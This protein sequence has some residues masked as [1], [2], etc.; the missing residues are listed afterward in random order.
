[1]GEVTSDRVFEA[2]PN[3]EVRCDRPCLRRGLVG[4]AAASHFVGVGMSGAG[5]CI[6][7]RAP[8]S[9]RPRISTYGIPIDD[10]MTCVTESA[11]SDQ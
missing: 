2:L 6:D 7:K 8:R 5:V 4:G 3:G 1:M 9:T 10:F 11:D